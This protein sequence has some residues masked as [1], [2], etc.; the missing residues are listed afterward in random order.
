MD[1][2]GKFVMQNKFDA[3]S[4]FNDGLAWVRIGQQHSYINRNGDVLIKPRYFLK[5]DSF[6]EGLAGVFVGGSLNSQSVVGK[7]GY[8][9]KAK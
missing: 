6:S 1:T 8:L 2:T 9:G 3:V 5:F 4:E 7:W